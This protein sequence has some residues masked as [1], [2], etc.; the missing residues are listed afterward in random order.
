MQDCGALSPEKLY[1]DE[2]FAGEEDMRGIEAFIAW[3]QGKA[4]KEIN[5]IAADVTEIKGD[6]LA[7]LSYPENSTCARPPLTY[8]SQFLRRSTEGMRS[9]ML[10]IT[11]RFSANP[12]N[13][14]WSRSKEEI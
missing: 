9:M 10:G 13:H 8:F 6:Y 5:R 2:E 7:G 14:D 1:E 11:V 3:F 12:Q 4:F